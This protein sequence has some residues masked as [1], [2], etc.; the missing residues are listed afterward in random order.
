MAAT[1][2]ATIE[3]LGDLPPPPPARPRVL[4]VATVLATAATVMVFAGLLGIYLRERAADHRRA[5]ARGCPRASPS[6]SRPAT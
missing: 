6:R 2:L 5:A 1:A 4:L 3:E